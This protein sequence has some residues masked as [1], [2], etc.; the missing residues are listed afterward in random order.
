MVTSVA[1][2]PDGRRLLSASRD[3]DA[4]LW[5]V[6]SGKVLRV[7]RAHF[8]P[9]SDARF[10][11]DARWIVTAGPRSVGLWE[12]STGELVSLLEGPPGPFRAV[13]FTPDSRTIVAVSE[14]GVVSRYR[15]RVCEGIPGLLEL[16]DER[17]AA[18]G[19]ELTPQERELYLG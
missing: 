15:C 1:F 5:D 4:I 19:R 3:R 10:S 6:A 2:S 18:T 13:A 7:L 11:P 8:G 17:L 12:A 9:V 14:G 16:A